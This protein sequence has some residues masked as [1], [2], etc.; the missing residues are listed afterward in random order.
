[1]IVLFLFSYRLPLSENCAKAGRVA[2][3]VLVSRGFGGIHNQDPIHHKL[4][5]MSFG[6]LPY[7]AFERPF[8]FSGR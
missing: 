2:T 4:V 1:M 8:V 3:G 7:D 6:E 5:F